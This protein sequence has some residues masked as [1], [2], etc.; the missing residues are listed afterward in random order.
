MG[1]IATSDG[2]HKEYRRAPEGTH[3]ARCVQ[4]IDIGNQKT[5]YDG[6]ARVQAKVIVG[7]ELPNEL[8]DGVPDG[9]NAR[10]PEPFLVW[11]RYTRSLDSRARLRAMLES[12][13]GEDFSSG[14]LQEFNLVNILE[15]PCMVTIKHNKVGD[16]TYAN[17]TAVTSMVKGIECPPQ[18][19]ETIVFDIDSWDQQVFEALGKGTQATIM[20]SEEMTSKLSEGNQELAE[21][22][23]QTQVTPPNDDIPF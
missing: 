12:W 14:D 4:L 8:D 13:R 10:P 9:E 6:R 11:C 16:K 23:M 2:E 22:E 15:K 21:S 7:W 19:H 5:E 17:V 20:K 3:V 18:S 1:L